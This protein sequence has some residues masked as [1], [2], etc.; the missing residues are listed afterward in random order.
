MRKKPYIF[1]TALF[2]S[3]TAQIF[4]CLFFLKIS[5][6]K[7]ISSLADTLKYAASLGSEIPDSFRNLYQNTDTLII[8][9]PAL[10]ESRFL[11]DKK[12]TF[13]AVS[14]ADSVLI[15][16]HPSEKSRRKRKTVIPA[17]IQKC[18][19]KSSENF[20]SAEIYSF[21]LSIRYNIPFDPLSFEAP[22]KTEV[23]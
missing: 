8:S 12:D 16:I 4:F 1:Y 19:F 14:A 7:K 11:T 2:L 9:M 21:P 20:F 10:S 17:F 15:S 3:L 5:A 22:E 13:T 6:H 18:T 23:F